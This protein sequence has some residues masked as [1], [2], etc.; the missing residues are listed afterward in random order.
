M[1]T[2]RELLSKPFRR[3]GVSAERRSLCLET[4]GWRRSAETPLRSFAIG[5]RSTGFPVSHGG[6]QATFQSPVPTN[7]SLLIQEQ[8]RVA[9]PEIALSG[10][11]PNPFPG[12]SNTQKPPQLFPSGGGRTQACLFHLLIESHDFAAGFRQFRTAAAFAA[13]RGEDERFLEAPVHRLDE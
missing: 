2:L 12:L 9:P 4:G 13:V 7:P 11:G 10:A 8:C 3:S 1:S 5:S 6:I